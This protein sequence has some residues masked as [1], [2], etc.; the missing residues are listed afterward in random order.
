M[1]ERLPNSGPY[2]YLIFWNDLKEFEST[3]VLDNLRVLY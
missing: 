3:S 1:E 2:F